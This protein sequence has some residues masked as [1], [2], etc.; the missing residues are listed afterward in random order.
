MAAEC[1]CTSRQRICD[2]RI[3]GGGSPL[4]RTRIA[5]G[6]GEQD[7]SSLRDVVLG[8]ESHRSWLRV[9]AVL[10]RNLLRELLRS[11]RS[12]RHGLKLVLVVQSAEDRPRADA[13]ILQIEKDWPCAQTGRLA[14]R[15]KCCATAGVSGDA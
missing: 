10:R 6:T 2:V 13:M 5:L 7:G 9:S 12:C 3:S 14:V 11:V 8:D 1:G 4:A 15:S